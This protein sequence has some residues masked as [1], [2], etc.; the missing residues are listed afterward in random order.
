MVDAIADQQGRRRQRALAPSA[1]APSIETAL[2]LFPAAA[3][4]WKPRVVTCSA[5][6]GEGVVEVWNVDPR[7][8]RELTASGALAARRSSQA[9]DWMRELI[10]SGLDDLLRRDRT[11]TSRLTAL[12]ASVRSGETTPFAAAREVV[13][14]FEA[15]SRPSS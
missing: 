8:P 15:R 10:T 2:H 1:L 14:A 5:L 13:E 3:D 12:E 4:G 11:I 9:L 7:T 6:T